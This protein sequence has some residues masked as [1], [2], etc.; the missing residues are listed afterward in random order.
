MDYFP[1]PHPDIWVTAEA[2]DSDALAAA[3]R[4]AAEHETPWS[5]DLAAVVA[6]NFEERSPWNET[7]GP[8]RPRGGPNGLILRGGKI[9]AEWGD[10]TWV[11]MT[12]SVAKSYLSILA[13]LAWDR[14]LIRDPGDPVRL[15]VDDG[16]FDPPHNEGITWHH[17]LQQTSE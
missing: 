4:Y 9:V 15:T 12:F 8:V 5:R 6:Q 13:G 14:E 11:D 2:P 17:L 16:G 10:T 1:P 7:L 3:A